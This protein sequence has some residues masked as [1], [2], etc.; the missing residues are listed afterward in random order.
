MLISTK[1][2]ELLKIVLEA[3]EQLPFDGRIY[4]IFLDLMVEEMRRWVS[5]WFLL[6]ARII[7]SAQE[8]EPQTK[9]TDAPEDAISTAEVGEDTC[10]ASATEVG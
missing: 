6:S 4:I 2:W 8:K 7:D 3:I 5:L 10:S 1:T 9:N